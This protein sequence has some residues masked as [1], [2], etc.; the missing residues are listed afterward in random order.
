MT[1]KKRKARIKVV[2]VIPEPDKHVVVLEVEDAP[3]IPEDYIY[4]PPVE[5]EPAVIDEHPDHPIVK[6]LKSL[7]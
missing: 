2:K 3:P 5:Q 4:V 7:W 6:W 1:Q